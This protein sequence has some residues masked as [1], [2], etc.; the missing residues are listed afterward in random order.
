MVLVGHVTKDGGARRARRRSSTWSTACSTSRASGRT[1]IASCARRKNRFG[2]TNEIGVF[3]MRAEGLGEVANPS[4]LFLAER[5]IGAPGSVGRRRGRGLAADPGRDPGAGGARR[6]ACRGGRRSGIDPQPRVAA[7]GGDRAARRHRRA[8]PGRLRQRRRR[9]APVRAGRRS[10][11][12]RGGG[13]LGAQP[14]G[15]SAHALLRRGRARRRGPRRRQ[16]RA[17]AGRGDASSA[18]AAASCP[19]CP[20]RGF[21]GKPE[22]E[23]VGV[24]RRRRRARGAHQL[25][26]KAD[27]GDRAMAHEPCD[28]VAAASAQASAPRSTR[29][30]GPAT[31]ATCR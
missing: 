17:A 2:S 30:S 10:R 24:A 14:A 16:R 22:L 23:L 6:P 27:A 31:S 21:H 13:L 25:R 4:A 20:A 19:S 18:S 28:I 3:E 15:R 1:T 5:P 26:P 29:S 8:R 7:A 9:R 12:G 11:R